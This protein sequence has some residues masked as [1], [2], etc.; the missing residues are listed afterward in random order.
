MVI[1]VMTMM[2]EQPM[3]KPVLVCLELCIVCNQ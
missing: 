1:T 2:Y 3:Q